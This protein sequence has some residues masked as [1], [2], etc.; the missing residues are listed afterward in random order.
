MRLSIISSPLV[1]SFFIFSLLQPITFAI[2]KSYVV[3]LGSH[4]HGLEPTQADI[5]RVTDSHYE[6]LGLFT[7][8]KEKAKEKIFYS[9]TNSIN[10]FAAVPEEEEASALAKHPDVVSVFLNKA[11]KL[12]TTHS[13]SFLGLEKDGVVPPSSLWKKARYGED[14]IIG[15]LDT[16]KAKEKIFYSYTNSINGFAAVLEEEEASA[17][18]KHPDVVSVFLNKA[19][20][21]HTTNS[22]SFLGLEKDGVVPPSSLWKKARYGEDAIIGNLD[23]G[24]W[25]ESKSFSDEG[26]G[27]VPSK[28]RGICQNATKEGV[29]CNRKLIGARY[30]NKGYGSIVGHLNS[31]FQTARD[32]EG[33]GTHTLS[34]AA[35]NFVPGANVFGNGKGTA[36]GG[37][38]RA[39]VA[40]YKV[41]WPAVGVNEGGCYEADILAGFDVAISDGVDVLSVSLGGAIDEYSDDAIAIGSFHAFKKGITVVASAGNSG[42]GPGSVSNVAPWLITVGAST[43]DR[44]FTIYVALG[45][46]KHLKGVSLSQKSLPARKFYPLISGARAKASNQSEEDANLCKP[47]TLDSEKVKGKILVCLRGVNPRVE[48]GHVALLA[49]A[50]GMILANDE[51]SG[52]GILADAHVLPAAHIIST[53]GQAVFSYLNSTKDPWA[54]ITNVR[55]ELGTKPA[56]FMASFSSRGPNILEESILKQQ[57]EITMGIQYWIRPTPGQLHLHTPN[58][59]AD[60]G[61]VYDLTVNDFLNYLC[62]RGYTAKDLKLF[63]DKPYTCPESF[64]L[65]DFNY[66]SISAINLNDTIT[67]TRRVKNVGSPGK[68]YIH[69]RE[70][71]GVLVSVTPATL[72]FKKL[73]EEKTFKVTFKLA[74]KWKL[75]DYTFG[76]LSWSDGKHFVRSPLV[77]SNYAPLKARLVDLF[78][79][80][81][82][83]RMQSS[84]DPA[85]M[86]VETREHKSSGALPAKP[87][88]E[89]LKA[90]EMSDGRVQFRKVSVPPHRYSPLKKAWME[91]YTPIYEQMKVD[92]RMNLKARKVELK[93]RSDTPDVSNLQKCAD[94]VHAFMLGFDV[95]DAIALLR[96]DELYVESFEIKDVKT[97]RGEHLSRAIGR[98]SGKGGK[99]KFAI[100]NAT[101]T[102]I[103]IADTKIHILGSFQNIKVARD[104][105]CSLILGSPAGKVYSK[106]RQVTAR[107]AERF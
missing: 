95:I 19:R 29:P 75:K 92:V 89:P 82:A 60:P 58:R 7:E 16:E 99:T 18:A 56:P 51:E 12:H 50:V 71:T 86:E 78:V 49:R 13:W 5:D 38:P 22:W 57:Q 102:R 42:P 41:C 66:P 67:V 83:V 30:F 63:T 48:K 74:P 65:T 9:Y 43:L 104:S 54:Y 80:L 93:T 39:R 98:L 4:S 81:G 105:L 27:P 21:L 32:I 103:V 97:L 100:E 24:V 69:V 106:L 85:S 79:G 3:Y 11:R 62:S 64:S 68:Y 8:S 88:F 47:G 17:L 34:T 35:G 31:S 25:P 37:S 61:L 45:N 55:T 73:G 72:E 94:F 77:T 91:I 46:R 53:D 96:L 84:K 90:H 23:T 87:K 20:K 10:G 76:V 36:K 2:K 59:A 40:A 28:W 14:V 107:L 33:H 44:A 101:K 52:N 6:L 15:N 1:L 26:L 70:P